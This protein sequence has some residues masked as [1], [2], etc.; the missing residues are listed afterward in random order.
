M[1]EATPE[2]P[3]PDDEPS[4]TVARRFAPGFV[5]VPVGAVLSTR[6]EETIADEVTLPAPSVTTTRRSKRP[7]ETAVVSKLAAYGDVVSVP[8]VVQTPP[9]AG[10]R[11]NTTESTPEPP[12]S[13]AEA[14][15]ET[16]PRLY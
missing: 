7:S 8:I 12:V 14:G 5:S 13:P 2:P 1:T 10:E 11:W 16:G 9:P 3:S 4:V 15:S 6:R